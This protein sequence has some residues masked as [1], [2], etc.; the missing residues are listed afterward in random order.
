MAQREGRIPE[1]VRIHHL[2]DGVISV[3]F[4]LKDANLFLAFLY[5]FQKRRSMSGKPLLRLRIDPYLLG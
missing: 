2:S 1:K 4:S 3:F 5:E